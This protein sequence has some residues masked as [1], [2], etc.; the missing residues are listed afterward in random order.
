MEDFWRTI[1]ML[2]F[3][4][5]LY[6]DLKPCRASPGDKWTDTSQTPPAECSAPEADNAR[7]NLA[8]EA[9]PVNKL[10]NQILIHYTQPITP[11]AK[12]CTQELK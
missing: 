11:R 2:E 8:S 10:T 12:N 1:F 9:M 6:L 5:V 3:S 7:T 4:I